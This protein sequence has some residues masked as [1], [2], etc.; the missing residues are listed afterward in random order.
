MSVMFGRYCQIGRKSLGESTHGGGS[1]TLLAIYKSH[2]DNFLNE[3]PGC[4]S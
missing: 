2:T 3:A 4:L 1:I